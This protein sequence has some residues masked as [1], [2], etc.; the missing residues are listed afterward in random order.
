MKHYKTISFTFFL[1]F[2]LLGS[3][4]VAQNPSIRNKDG[5]I[6]KENVIKE[7]NMYIDT[8]GRLPMT[9]EEG[10]SVIK[11]F[12]L[13]LFP[14]E[15]KIRDNATYPDKT[16][17]IEQ[18]SQ[19]NSDCFNE[20]YAIL[21][22]KVKEQTEIASQ[23]N[24]APEPENTGFQVSFDW[25]I[26]ALI[27]CVVIL[28]ILIIVFARILKKNKKKPSSYKEKPVMTPPVHHVDTGDAGIVV[29]RKTESIMKK[30]C[31]D[32]VIENSN[33]LKIEGYDFCNDTAVRRI[34]IKNTCIK[35]IYNIY[36]DDLR[37]PN[38]PK[39]DGCMVLGR[40][41]HN[42]T[43]N[44][45]DVSLEE[46]VL[47]GDDAVFSEYE[48]NFGGKIKLKATE[49][50]K[51]LRR[52]T[53]QQ[54]DLTCWV[55]SHPGLGVFFSNSDSNVQTQLKHPSH[56][57]F[58]TAF[59][60]DILTPKQDLGI[61]TFKHDTSI[62]SKTDLKKLYSLEEWYQWALESERNS[63]QEEDHYDTLSNANQRT[64]H[65]YSIQFNNSAIIDI[66]LLSAN[67]QG[68]LVRWIHG[69]SKGQLDRVNNIVV[70]V[71]ETDNENDS[72]LI[73]AFVIAP[74][75]S[76]PSIRKA[77]AIH[78]EQIK[79][80]A[81]YSTSNGLLTSIPIVDKDLCSDEK[82]YGEQKLEDLKIWTRRKR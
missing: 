40:W 44:E 58:L 67:S 52:E 53:D 11:N 31:L 34:Y 74:H 9:E 39:E 55:H 54:Y 59:V 68:E 57:N 71:S 2:I 61:F 15:I 50:L 25:R 4:V 63:F 8:I 10:W 36:A 65:C 42:K 41:V 69:F 33:Y 1:L 45:Y 14:Y 82:Y 18:Q 64:N 22:K 29:R 79:F 75:C 13:Y 7:F 77:I 76:I 5:S 47:P 27:G 12:T 28:V 23:K 38:N 49:R 6:D 16:Y 70:K 32:D 20:L 48:L 51:K 17:T 72:E 24:I 73:G 60:V 78:I 43:S 62:N 81:V 37:N 26:G 30:Q 46:I 19:I 66:S 21:D 3:N 35:D 56:P 80:V